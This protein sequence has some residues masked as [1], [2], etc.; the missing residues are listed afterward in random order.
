MK[1][2]LLLVMAAGLVFTVNAQSKYGQS[3]ERKLRVADG[4]EVSIQQDLP[5]P[6]LNANP[7]KTDVDR[8]IIGT[9]T[10]MKGL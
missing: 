1:K 7:T 6:V 2:L 5:K 8:V 9:A 4:Q 10:S 3:N